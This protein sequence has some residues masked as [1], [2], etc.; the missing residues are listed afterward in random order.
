MVART[1]R[2][3]KNISIVGWK[4]ASRLI[5]RKS[6]AIYLGLIGIAGIFAI[7]EGW[8]DQLSQWHESPLLAQQPNYCYCKL[9]GK[10]NVWMPASTCK[11]R[12]GK[13]AH[14]SR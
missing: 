1:K 3:P 5:W 8:G 14:G 6:L 13:C 4:H 7:G 2:S 11:K 12:G 9:P 10:K